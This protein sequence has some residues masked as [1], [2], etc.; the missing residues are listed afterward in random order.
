[1]KKK[2][3][4]KNITAAVLIS[5]AAALGFT[6][7]TTYTMPP[8]SAATHA[9]TTTAAQSKAKAAQS[10]NTFLNS[11]YKPALKGQFPDDLNK[12]SKGL[13]LGKTKRDELIDIF[14]QPYASGTGAN[15]FDEYESSMGQPGF[16]FSYKKNKLQEMRYFGTGVERQT[17]LGSITQHMLMK[18]WGMPNS[19]STIKA[20]K[21]TQKK[22]V[23]IRGK[24]QLEFIFNSS[25]D[26]NHV[27]LTFKGAK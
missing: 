16:A 27:N 17:N 13:T 14:G 6:G 20:G 22:M 23:Y 7:V 1:M 12:L 9:P 5:G 10:V 2:P 18:Q 24:Y 19:T 3:S 25:T 4:A 15:A 26:L 8:V 21:I 11:F